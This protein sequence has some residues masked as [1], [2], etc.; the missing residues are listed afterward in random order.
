MRELWTPNGIQLKTMT[1][2]LMTQ[3]MGEDW[4]TYWNPEESAYAIRT[5]VDWDE[6]LF[7]MTAGELPSCGDVADSERNPWTGTTT[8]ALYRDAWG[9]AL[10]DAGRNLLKSYIANKRYIS[11]SN[12]L[13]LQ[14][15]GLGEI[16]GEAM[17]ELYEKLHGWDLGIQINEA[18][19]LI[20]DKSFGGWFRQE[21]E[22]LGEA[23]QAEGNCHPGSGCQFCT[24]RGTSRCRPHRKNRKIQDLTKGEIQLPEDVRWELQKQE[25]RYGVAFDVGSTTIAA[26]LWNLSSET[27]TPVQSMARQNPLTIYGRDVISRIHTAKGEPS[28]I[29][30]MQRE[31]VEALKQMV[32]HLVDDLRKTMPKS[33]PVPVKIRRLSA[34]GNPA[35]MHFLFGKDPSGLAAA[36]FRGEELPLEI[37]A[38]SLGFNGGRT[39][40]LD[41]GA[42]LRTLPV[43]GGHLGADAAA[44]L[45][46]ARLPEERE[47]LLLVDVGTNG[48]LLLTD[49]LGRLWGC[50]TAAGPAFEGGSITPGSKFID[51]AASMLEQG[52]MD[53]EGLVLRPMLLSQEEIRQLQL[54][55][56]AVRTGV[57]LLQTIAG[58]SRS[59]ILLT[60]TFGSHIKPKSAVK[61][62]I[63]PGGVEI[64]SAGNL[65][66][67]GASLILL[68]D[69][70]WK[71]GIAWTKTV[72]HVE[73]AEEPG[74][75]EAFVRNMDFR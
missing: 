29:E 49:G 36:P 24:L 32:D 64:H 25:E 60:G 69:E 43:M 68:S 31:L 35:M 75:E 66:G 4:R 14:G 6:E 3:R 41:D 58:V 42:T 46:A 7:L 37:T 33:S 26:M 34:V 67:V 50:S 23:K 19:V 53:E 21:T 20:P 45:L 51:A 48:E 1:D 57:E 40:T 65:A 59:E 11:D 61:I 38:E 47:P 62:G 63:L 72:T 16:P 17:R 71:Q 27:I 18:C 8:E 2:E 28:R 44:A 5:I 9:T 39:W 15:P 74:F 13:K 73:L 54:A 52:W 10:L 22:Y 30:K 55:K 56:S 70:E 12:D